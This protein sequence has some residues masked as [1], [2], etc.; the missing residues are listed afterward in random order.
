MPVSFVTDEGRRLR[1]D[2]VLD[3]RPAASLKAGGMG[4]RYQCVACGRPFH[5]FFE[6][7]R[8]FMERGSLGTCA[9]DIP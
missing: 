5:L 7:D 1:I 9:D 4:I 2:R 6:E 3:I 8:W